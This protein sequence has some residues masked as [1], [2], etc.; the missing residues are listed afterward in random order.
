MN[1]L[2]EYFA[3][4]TSPLTLSLWAHAP[5]A[6]GPDGP[7]AGP[8]YA[9]PY[10]GVQLVFTPGTTLE[11]AGR[12]YSLPPRFDT[13]GPLATHIVGAQ[14]HAQAAEA[15]HATFFTHVSICAPCSLNPDF[16]VTINDTFAFSPKFA[17]DGSPRFFGTAT[18][19]AGESAPA[20]A[21]PLPWMFQGY[22]SI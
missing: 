1:W 21:E 13:I 14:A 6:L 17:T 19:H 12:A 2:A 15:V 18:K 9:L 7:V 5:L 8:V 20:H 11:Y 4:R 22:I 3:H 16:L 10:P